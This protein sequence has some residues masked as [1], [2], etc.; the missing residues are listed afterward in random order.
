MV[1]VVLS[2]KTLIKFYFHNNMTIEL[3]KSGGDH[4]GK[5]LFFKSEHLKIN[6]FELKKNY[7]RGGHYHDYPVTYVLI[8]GKIQHRMKS[9]DSE[10]EIIEELSAPAITKIS[11]N[12]SNLVIGINNSLF[13]EMFDAE[14]NSKLYHEYRN[15]VIEKNKLCNHIESDSSLNIENEFEDSR[16]KIFFL[17]FN[18]KNCNLIELKKN[19]ARGGHYHKFESEHIVLDGK[20]EYFENNLETDSESTKIITNPEIIITKPYIAHMFFGLKNSYFIES[21]LGKYEAIFYD[22][23]RK[24]VEEK[25]S[26]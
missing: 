22:N 5:I 2:L 17:K 4:R 21:F 18:G 12:T 6:F 13:L 15:I 26:N 9:L 23:Y 7:A 8:S 1:T 19:Y 11:P 3:I 16:G 24:I 10:K 20:I 14:Y 25:M